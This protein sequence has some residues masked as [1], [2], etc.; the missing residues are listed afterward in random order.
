MPKNPNV[1]IAR[2]KAR[3]KTLLKNVRLKD[4]ISLSR[5]QPYFDNPDDFKLSQSQLVIARELHAKS[6][7]ELV[8]REDWLRCSF[9]KKWQ[10]EF[11]QLIAGP[12]D[13]YVC[14]E[15]VDLCNQITGAQA[16]RCKLFA[17]APGVNAVAFKLA[18]W[19]VRLRPHDC[20][21]ACW[22]VFAYIT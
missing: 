1:H 2:F 11:E 18:I 3:A 15:C 6:W 16:Q 7:R 4:P 10:Y 22:P 21:E 17:V 13:I 8:L 14:N 20:S 5:I 9:C 19:H 12:D